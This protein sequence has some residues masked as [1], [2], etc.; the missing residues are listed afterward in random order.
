MNIRE[1][2][3]KFSTEDQCLAYIESM[4]WPDGV[5]RCPTCGDTNIT[6]YERPKTARKPRNPEKPPK[7]PDKI[8]RRQWFYICLKSDCRQQFSPTSG[9]LFADTHLPLIVWFHA[10]GLVLNAKKGISAKQLQ[11]D[12]GIGG[13][14]TAWY[15]LHRIRESMAEANPKPLGGTV[16][17]DETYIGGR[18]KGKGVYFGINQKQAVMGAVERGGELRLRHVPDS[19]AR[20]IRGFVSAHISED[21]E[22]VYTDQATAYPYALAPEFIARHQTVNHIIGEYARGDVYTNSIESAFS[23]LKRGMIGQFHKLSA[24]H[25][26]RYLS[27]FEYRFNGRRNDD[28]FIETVRRLCGFPPLR[29]ADLTSD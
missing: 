29:F 24:K 14:K 22:H 18:Q 27:E 10:I 2:A 3:I 25:L 12:L 15:L 6:K 13:Y 11:R 4:K 16:E 26:H 23:L 9:T 17:I 19:K 5:V 1:I 21:A 8:N 20:T 7:N 28:L